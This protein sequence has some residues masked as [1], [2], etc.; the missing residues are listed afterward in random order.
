MEP[1]YPF[2][3]NKVYRVKSE[4]KNNYKAQRVA[5]SAQRRIS[6]RKPFSYKRCQ[7]KALLITAIDKAKNT[8]EVG[9][10]I[11][12]VQHYEKAQG[13]NQHYSFQPI[14]YADRMK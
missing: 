4:K 5:K 6:E 14:K 7:K 10:L 13:I 3:M 11:N 8:V 2:D 9:K 1:I 12:Q